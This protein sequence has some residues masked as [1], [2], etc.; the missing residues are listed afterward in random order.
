MEATLET[1]TAMRRQEDTSYQTGDFLS[2]I[3]DSLLLDVDA[4][5]RTKMAEWCFQVTEFCQFS[6]E[7][8][9]IAINY[10]DRFLLADQSALQDRAVFQLAAMTCLYMAVK[11]HEPEAMCPTTVST[12]SRNT[13][14]PQDIE[15]MERQ[16]LSA[17]KWRVNPPTSVSF[18]R[19]ML[20]LL[21]DGLLTTRQR[22]TMEEI[23]TLQTELAVGDYNL[24]TVKPSTIAYCSV[25]NALESV[26]SL[27]PKTVAYM[28]YALAR[29]VGIDDRDDNEELRTMTEYLLDAVE[30]REPEMVARAT[31]KATAQE[32]SASHVQRRESFHASP[33]TTTATIR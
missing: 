23:A 22:T 2:L 18:V 20:L 14:T 29:A 6:K 27:E 13:Y 4:D 5:C 28:V 17:L 12:L 32:P 7:S 21:P 26:H 19:Q 25:V 1:I 16:I 24:I 3:R 30:Q 10:L 15:S 9:E 31:T 11:I 33:R 8:A